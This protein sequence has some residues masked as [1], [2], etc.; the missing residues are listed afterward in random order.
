MELLIEE[1]LWRPRWQGALQAWQGQGNR[2]QLLRGRRCDQVA[3]TPAPWAR[4]PPAGT[5]SASGLH[6]AWL[7]EG[8]SHLTLSLIHL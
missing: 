2:W 6:A 1:A 3:V 7:G 8:E 4:C 5:P